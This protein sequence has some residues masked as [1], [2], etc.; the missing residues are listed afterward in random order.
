VNV[1]QRHGVL[2][3]QTEQACAIVPAS[4]VVPEQRVRGLIEP[5]NGLVIIIVFHC[6]LPKNANRF[7]VSFACV[8]VGW[9]S[10]G[11]LNTQ[12]LPARMCFLLTK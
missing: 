9:R 8:S 6:Q 10:E 7:L 1:P 2:P 5:V 3:Y 12:H 11:W 4:V